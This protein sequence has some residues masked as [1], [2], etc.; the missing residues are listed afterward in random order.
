MKVQY[1]GPHAQ[2]Q[3]FSPKTKFFHEDPAAQGDCGMDCGAAG[4]M[5]PNAAASTA[6]NDWAAACAE[7]RRKLGANHLHLFPGLFGYHPENLGKLQIQ[8]AMLAVSV[9]VA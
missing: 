9:C 8:H 2:L 3:Y 4:A 1:S 6:G 7:N 5:A